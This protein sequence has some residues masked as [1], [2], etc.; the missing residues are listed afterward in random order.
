MFL[1]L[2]DEGREEKIFLKKKCCLHETEKSAQ[3][4]KSN[5]N[6]AHTGSFEKE[7]VFK[8]IWR[9]HVVFFCFLFSERGVVSKGTCVLFRSGSE[10]KK[11]K[12]ELFCVRIFLSSS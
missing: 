3:E 9:N 4:K 12:K 7:K 8:K 2:N 5:K 1:F 10:R 6:S 11:K